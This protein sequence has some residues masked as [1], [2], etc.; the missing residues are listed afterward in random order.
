M[1][2]GTFSHQQR[3]RSHREE[4]AHQDSL[5]RG[6]PTLEEHASLT[7]AYVLPPAPDGQPF[8]TQGATSVLT[9]TSSLKFLP[10]IPCEREETANGFEPDLLLSD[11][12]LA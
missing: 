12:G 11:P 3:P 8:R 9:V 10:G 7:R 6:V 5:G 2:N 1:W 4:S